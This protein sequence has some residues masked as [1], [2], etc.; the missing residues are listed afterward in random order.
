MLAETDT[1]SG[2]ASWLDKAFDAASEA[3]KRYPGNAGLRVELARIAE[4]QG[5]TQT[6]IEHYSKAVDIEDSYRD[7]FRTIYPEREDVVS[8]L[9][10][11]KYLFAKDRLKSLRQHESP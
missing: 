2:G 5:R 9:G 1:P 8:R 11:D 3:V 4:G 7:Q 6:A 10:E